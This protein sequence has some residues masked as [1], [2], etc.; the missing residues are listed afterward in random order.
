MLSSALANDGGINNNGHVTF[1]YVSVLNDE[2]IAKSPGSFLDCRAVR[3]HL[4]LA[5]TF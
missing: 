2:L 4:T 1:C 5:R 3:E